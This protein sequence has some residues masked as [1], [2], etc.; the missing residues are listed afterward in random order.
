[1]DDVQDAIV[2]VIPRHVTEPLEIVHHFVKI[3][4]LAPTASFVNPNSLVTQPF[5][6]VQVS[7]EY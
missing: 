4:P 3:I 6:A 7:V 2:T 5:K 1:M